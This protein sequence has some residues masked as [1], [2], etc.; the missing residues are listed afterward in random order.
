MKKV[1]TVVLGLKFISLPKQAPNSGSTHPAAGCVADRRLGARV[2]GAGLG[3]SRC[4]AP[5]R[6]EP[7]ALAA[8][9]ANQRRP[10]RDKKETKNQQRCRPLICTGQN[11]KIKDTQNSNAKPK[12]STIKLNQKIDSQIL[13]WVVRVGPSDR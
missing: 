7:A 12:T 10:C 8:D 3:H 1:C 9:A 6:P 2:A 5:D 13:M 4:H 11:C